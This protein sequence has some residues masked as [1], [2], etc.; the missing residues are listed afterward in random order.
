M[1]KVV[2]LKNVLQQ[3]SYDHFAVMVGNNHLEEGSSRAVIKVNSN[4]LFKGNG[5]IQ[6]RSLRLDFPK[7]DGLEPMEW[8]LKVQQIFSYCSTPK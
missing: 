8:F 4:M 2:L 3:T 1:E 6:V 5:G 7:F